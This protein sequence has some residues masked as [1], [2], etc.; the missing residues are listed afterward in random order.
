[1]T[2]DSDVTALPASSVTSWDDEAD[3]VIAGYGVAGA[4][5]AF[6]AAR[7]RADVLVTERTGS[8]GGAATMAGGFIYLGGVTAGLAAWGYA[9]GISLGDGSF[10][11]RR[12]GRS[13]A[14]G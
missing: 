1:M 6:E 8:R 4:A 11:G 12:A 3:V 10:Y 13:A 5:A 7:S 14:K 9:S 2:P